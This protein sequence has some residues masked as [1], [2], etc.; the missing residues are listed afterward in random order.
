M[1]IA[2][3]NCRIVFCTGCGMK[4]PSGD[5]QP[6]SLINMVQEVAHTIVIFRASQLVCAACTYKVFVNGQDLGLVGVGKSVSM[7]VFS[8][9]VTV[10]I[11][12]T[13]VMM[14]GHQ[15]HATL[16]LLQ[17]PRVNFKLE[18]G[19]AINATVDGAEILSYRSGK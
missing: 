7:Q 11:C 19:G 3:K 17:N 10:D 2:G 16:K 14:S 5:S 13:T 15:L 18:Y 9:T 8:D 1:H 6:F 4:L 12:C